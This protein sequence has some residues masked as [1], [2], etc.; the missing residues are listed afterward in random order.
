M[1]A[2]DAAHAAM[3]NAGISYT[4]LLVAMA[5]QARTNQTRYIEPAMSVTL[6]EDDLKTLGTEQVAAQL[7]KLQHEAAQTGVHWNLML[8]AHRHHPPE[9]VRRHMQTALQLRAAG[10]PIAALGCA[11]GGNITPVTQWGQIWDELG[12]RGKLVLVPHA[13]ELSEGADTFENINDALTA[14]PNRIAHGV[15][16]V[17]DPALLKHLASQR[18]C[19]DVA[20]SSNEILGNTIVGQHPIVTMVRA[21]VPCSINTD[22]S[23]LLGC[24]LNGE[25]E[26]AWQQGLSWRELWRCAR[27]AVMFSGAPRALRTTIIAEQTRWASTHWRLLDRYKW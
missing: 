5:D 11:G 19:C 26:L 10:A 25:Y 1:V 16:A 17:Q 23:L 14:R 7:T 8:M 13:G 9:T 18:I 22:D 21:G 6:L 24:T 20:I 2:Y 27:D 12:G 4:D 15:Q 3:V